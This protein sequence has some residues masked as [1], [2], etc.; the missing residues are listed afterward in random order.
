M[1]RKGDTV[2]LVAPASPL[3]D[4]RD[5]SRAARVL[6]DLGFQ[7]LE[8]RHI[9]S[10]HG[11]LAGSDRDRLSDIH[12]MFEDRRV[13]AVMA[14][15][16][17]YGSSRLLDELD[18]ELIVAN[19]KVLVGHSDLTALLNTLTQRTGMVTF[20]GPMAGY[21][22]GRSP[23]L[24]KTRHLMAVTCSA[25]S[26]LQ[27]PSSPP[28][29]R[30]KMQVISAGF[31][32]GRLVGGNLS[33]ICSM[34]GTPYEI[35][36]TGRILFFEEVDEEPYRIDRMLNQLSQAGKLRAAAGII[37]GKCVNCESSGR[38]KR[39]FR[40]ADVLDHWLGKLGRPV[41]YGLPVGHE[42]EKL[43]LPIGVMARLDAEGKPSV[44]LLEPAVSSPENQVA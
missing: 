22:L 24:F 35:N 5:I 39:T 13:R 30:R 18:W 40:L 42:K 12:H 4:I 33:I 41:V 32:E 21:D 23:S 43:T 29:P 6:T 34:L 14:V 31:A 44:T 16:G 7:V 2:G 28:S 38:M 26:P 25:S 27:L 11:F 36:T 8:G 15:R 37:V 19:P 9:R 3:L 10:R 1:L 17:G 20:W